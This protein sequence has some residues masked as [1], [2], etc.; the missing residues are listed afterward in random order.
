LK[1][2]AAERTVPLPPMVMNTLRE[3]KL[4]CPKGDDDLVFPKGKGNVDSHSNTVESQQVVL[5]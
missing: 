5:R 3:W 2:E 4:A 1:S